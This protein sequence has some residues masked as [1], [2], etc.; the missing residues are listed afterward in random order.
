MIEGRSKLTE[1]G[2]DFGNLYTTNRGTERESH[3]SR[4]EKEVNV[5][6][7]KAALESKKN[8]ERTNINGVSSELT[9]M[10]TNARILLVFL[11]P[12]VT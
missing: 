2:Y 3:K 5:S 11:S 4:T 12:K 6:Q 10:S 9:G 1:D 7:S 8:E